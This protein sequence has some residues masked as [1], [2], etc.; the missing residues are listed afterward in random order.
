MS[1][2]S[3]LFVCLGNICRSPLAEAAFRKAA[4]E[5]GLNVEVASAG[6]A[7]YHVGQPPDPRSIDEA[8]RNGIDI[9]SYRGRQLKQQDFHEFDY[10]LGMDRS[11]MANIRRI[12][13]DG[14]KARVA[15]L[16][17]LVPGQHG[18]EVGDPY[19]G[20]EEGFAITWSEVDAGARALVAVM[21]DEHG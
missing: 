11:N 7:D 8:D 18:R 15:M 6:T 14:G 4:E 9:R 13:P 16:L 5:A 12:E 2:P 3:V 17:D 1:K 21:I 20:G 19:Y 10:I